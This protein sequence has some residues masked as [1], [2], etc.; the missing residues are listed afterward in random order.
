MTG[1]V[2]DVA[3]G[4]KVQ[5]ALVIAQ[6]RL[7]IGRGDDGAEQATLARGSIDGSDQRS[8]GKRH[9]NDATRVKLG[10]TTNFFFL[11]R[12]DCPRVA[13]N[14]R[15]EFKIL[16]YDVFPGGHNSLSKQPARWSFTR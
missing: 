11:A 6:R 9:E 4:D 5:V 14:G 1:Q 10:S 16:L 2:L 7:E 15:R 3:G 13:S 12:V 8:L